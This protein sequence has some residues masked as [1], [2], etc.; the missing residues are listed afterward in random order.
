VFK[1]FLKRQLT[2]RDLWFQRKTGVL[3]N[4]PGNELTFDLGF[5]V[6]HL[7]Q[8]R[9]PLTFVQ[10]GAYDGM[11]NDVLADFIRRGKLRG[12]LVEPQP[13]VFARLVENNRGNPGLAFENTAVGAASG[14]ATFYRVKAEYEHLVDRSRQMSGFSPDVILKHYRHAVPDPQVVLE[15]ISVPSMPLESLLAKHGLDTPD[16]LQI[17]TEGHDYAILRE[18]DFAKLRPA[19]ICYETAHLSREDKVKSYELLIRNDYLLYEAGL[20]CLA[21]DRAVRESA[22][23][24]WH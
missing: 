15:T 1:S 3:I 4:H 5:A 21:Y 23:G 7:L 9:D 6:A 11:T 18:L 17:D 20:D 19:I 2:A 24:F 12:L 13:E 10:V 8:R 16:V 22:P 14:A